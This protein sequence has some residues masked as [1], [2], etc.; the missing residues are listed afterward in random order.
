MP[1]ARS[2]AGWGFTKAKWQPGAA[3]IYGAFATAQKGYG[4]DQ[5]AMGL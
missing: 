5:W 2:S 1:A 4:P 3:G